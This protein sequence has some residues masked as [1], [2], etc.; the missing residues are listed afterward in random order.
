MKLYLYRE[1]S[2]NDN[3][4]QSCKQYHSINSE[5]S[6][7]IYG[8]LHLLQVTGN[9]FQRGMRTENLINVLEAFEKPIGLCSVDADWSFRQKI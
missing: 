5:R 4:R 3:E 6:R 7:T 2:Y 1:V 8:K 9:S